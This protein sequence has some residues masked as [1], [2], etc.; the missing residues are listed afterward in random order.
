[1]ATVSVLM[2]VFNTS[3]Y[4]GQAIASILAQ[5]YGDFRF[6]I[7]DDASSDDSWL[8]IQ[9]YAAADSRIVALRNST[10]EGIARSR[11]RLIAQVA[12]P[13]FAWMDS[14]DISTPDRLRCQVACLDAHPQVV[15]V[16]SG[17]VILGAER[18]LV[19]RSSPSKL[20]VDM[21]FSNQ[22]VNP[23][24]MVRT[25]AAQASAFSFASCGV[26]SATDYAFWIAMSRQGQLAVLPRVHLH[27][28]IHAGQ[29]STAN[30]Q[31]QRMS[32][33]QLAAEQLRAF[34]LEVP[35]AVV[36]DL[37]LFAGDQPVTTAETVGDLYLSLLQLNRTT[38]AF[39]ESL[40]RGRLAENYARYCKFFGAGGVRAF[41]QYLGWR[42]LLP[43]RYCGLHFIWRCLTY[44]GD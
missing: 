20:A 26:K 2:P 16:S 22:I 35:A 12:T 10:N 5:E 24:A 11:D 18:T 19:K 41:I 34:G 4:L 27:Y 30:K 32:A 43:M 37:Y 21:L 7:L 42:S 15:A 1:M 38:R 13:Y 8:I 14:D 29:E 28:R 39:D 33:K 40:L 31:L 9:G 23:A 6:Y 36:P 25:A 44:T 17:Y 3:A